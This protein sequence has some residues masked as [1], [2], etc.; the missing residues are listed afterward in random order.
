MWIAP[1][2]VSTIEEEKEDW[3]EGGGFHS[4]EGSP[5]ELIH[6]LFT[7]ILY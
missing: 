5:S 3:G 7:I 6:S 4:P 1:Q 2:R